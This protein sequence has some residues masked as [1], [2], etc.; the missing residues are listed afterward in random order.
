MTKYSTSF[1]QES[2]EPFREFPISKERITMQ[3]QIQHDHGHR[4]FNHQ[5]RNNYIPQAIIQPFLNE[6]RHNKTHRP[7]C[8]K[9]DRNL[10]TEINNLT[11]GPPTGPQNFFIERYD[12]E[13]NEISNVKYYELNKMHLQIHLNLEMEKTGVQILSR[14][15]AI[16]IKAFAVE[17]TIEESVHK[18]IKI[19][20]SVSRI[21]QVYKIDLK[22]YEEEK[23]SLISH[24]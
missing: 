15:K 5:K 10:K 19:I 13:I 8:R 21:T 6:S 23:K 2:P 16:E 24:R 3:H 12:C 11:A 7:S 1:K 22:N 20:R 17:A 9:I 18:I 4:T 14:A